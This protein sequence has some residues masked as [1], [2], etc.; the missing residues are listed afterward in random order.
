MR[1]ITLALTL[2]MFFTT[3][4][5][6]AQIQSCEIKGVFL[7]NQKY[8][9]AFLVD[10]KLKT[11]STSPIIK[12]AFSFTVTKPNDDQIIQLFLEED[13]AKSINYFLNESKIASNNRRII[14][15]EDADI[16]FLK[17]A[18]TVT[19]KTGALNQDIEQMYLAINSRNYDQFINTHTNS[20][21]SLYFLNAL[22]AI[23]KKMKSGDALNCKELFNK[24]SDRL[25]NSVQGK[26][27]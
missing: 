17:D 26:E 18:R 14:A 2:I 3:L 19:V 7:D 11:I 15:V 8:K 10:L 13:S 4:E 9:Y 25:K 12:D 16:L 1:K 6:K 24:L 21:I 22:V 27:I 20:P 5:M 23:N